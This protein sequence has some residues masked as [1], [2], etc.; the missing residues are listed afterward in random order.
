MLDVKHGWGPGLPSSVLGDEEVGEDG[1]LSG[2]GDEGELGG[3]SVGAQ[4]SVE[5]SDIGVVA[6]GGEGGEIEHAA[7]RGAAAADDAL[8]VALA[9]LVGDGGEAGEHGDRFVGEA[10][11]LGEARRSG[12]PRRSAPKPGIEVRMAKRRAKPCVGLDARQDRALERGDVLVE[13]GD[14]PG[15]LLA[16]E[17]DGG[18]RR[19]GS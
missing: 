19:A 18:G 17:G 16:E 15:E 12:W 11:E 14:A 8:A 2:D 13:A 9:G 1:E 4:A 3:L 7:H 10:A 6:G 5:G